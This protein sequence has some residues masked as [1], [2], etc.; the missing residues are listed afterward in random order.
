MIGTQSPSRVYKQTNQM[1]HAD[2]FALTLCG[3]AFLLFCS[4]VLSFSLST[5][6]CIEIEARREHKVLSEFFARNHDD[7][8]EILRE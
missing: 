1:T 3:Q 2:T 4:H 5:G 8:I 6:M 7:S